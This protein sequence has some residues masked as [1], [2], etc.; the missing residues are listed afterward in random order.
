[1]IPDVLARDPW[2]PTRKRRVLALAVRPHSLL[3]FGP[4]EESAWRDP[5]P[6]V[7]PNDDP[8]WSKAPSAEGA[9]ALARE[10]F[11]GGGIIPLV[12]ARH[13]ALEDL[14]GLA[15]ALDP[16][17]AEHYGLLRIALARH[18]LTALPTLFEVFPS[19]PA[20]TTEVLLRV[21]ATTVATFFLDRLETHPFYLARWARAHPE[22]F[23]LVAMPRILGDGE[24]RDATLK[25]VKWLRREFVREGSPHVEALRR[26]A[27][28]YGDDALAEYDA[29]FAPPPLPSRAPKLPQFVDLASLPVVV[30]TDGTPLPPDAMKR[31]VA[32]ATLLPQASARAAIDSALPA[33]ERNSLAELASVLLR[34]WNDAEG[35]SKERW[36]LHA[37]G[38]FGDD[39]V[40]RSLAVNLETWAST[41]LGARAKLAAEALAAIGSD[42]ALM[43]LSFL[44]KKK[45]VK[46]V[47]KVAETA[48]T[49]FAEAN[50]LSADE[51]ADR[52]VPDLGLDAKGALALDFGARSFRVGFDEELHP[53]VTDEGGERLVSLPRA[54]KNDDAAKAASAHELWAALKLEM[55]TLGAEQVRRLERAMV[56]GRSW[57]V[58]ELRRYFFEHPLMQNLARRVVWIVLYETPPRTF[59][60]AEDGSLADA[61]DA[62]FALPDV[63]RVG[64]AHPI[65]L[66]DAGTLER[67]RQ[68]FSDY[69]IVQPFPQLGREVL[70]P[71][72]DER[73]AHETARWSG[74]VARGDRF[75]S[76]KHR[77]WTFADY[78]LAKPLGPGE[79]APQ[80]V[81]ETKPGVWFLGQKPE[82]Q[83]LGVVKIRAATAGV[84]PTF[85][86]LPPVVVSELFRDLDALL[87]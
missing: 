21:D 62:P 3:A 13:V 26:G 4:G 34:A 19:W 49:R 42:L 76:L 82:D 14:P 84:H 80:A 20:P 70:T 44:T 85:G 2:V 10:I 15:P 43:H 50:E 7:E 68:L 18:G 63:A 16:R 74:K 46:A 28:R 69:A 78:D 6:T 12:T 32:L 73:A 52:L 65:A 1:M 67:F 33:L 39:R 48:L 54:N 40:V 45:R 55:K 51:L 75:F 53:F 66:R 77:G 27:A 56:A 23:A 58:P 83:T 61:D 11:L 59:R 60:V 47:A 57:S 30:T 8:V 71:T 35:P 31:L 64:I 24:D 25:L 29:I 36:M 9:R 72:D 38:L 81:L 5:A 37:A 17:F 86:E 22:T 87:R 41:G 79:G